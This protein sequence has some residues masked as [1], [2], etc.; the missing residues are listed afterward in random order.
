[1]N[2]GYAGQVPGP[3]DAQASRLR[4]QFKKGQSNG[5]ILLPHP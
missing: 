4:C 2:A 5:A 1:M 3:A